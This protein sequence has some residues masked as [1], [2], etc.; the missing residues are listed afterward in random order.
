[1]QFYINSFYLV[2]FIYISSYLVT[3]II[4]TV[5]NS[6]LHRINTCYNY[7]C[8]YIKYNNIMLNMTSKNSSKMDSLALNMHIQKYRAPS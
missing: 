6:W 3:F 2:T 7:N 5:I 8:K 4:Q 1:M